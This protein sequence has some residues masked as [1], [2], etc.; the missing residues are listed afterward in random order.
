M[1]PVSVAVPQPGSEPAAG[2]GKIKGAAFRE[3]VA[4]V[5]KDRGPEALARL[6]TGLAADDQRQYLPGRPALGLLA[7]TWYP[8]ALIHRFLDELTVG[9]PDAELE[10]MARKGAE[11][12]MQTNL[13]G[14]Y[15]SLFSLFVSPKIYAMGMQQ[16]WN[17]HYDSGRVGN[18]EAGPNRHRA[19]IHDWRGHHPFICRLNMAAVFPLYGAMGCRD[20]VAEREACV[21]SG[22]AMCAWNITWSGR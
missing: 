22:D 16:L 4:W 21:S 18:L 5:E 20:L 7:A 15:R 2:K 12:T 1:F 11:Y 13:R 10:R 9:L 8:A 14:V 19:V 17:L 3:F 6:V